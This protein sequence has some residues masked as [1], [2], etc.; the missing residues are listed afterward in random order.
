[1]FQESVRVRAGQDL[2][3]SHVAAKLKLCPR[4]V[5]H[6]VAQGKLH[7]RKRGEKIFVYDPA[8]VNALIEER[9]FRRRG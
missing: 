9:H 6:L 3:T 2:E 4:M 8:E 7:P 1:M 5:R